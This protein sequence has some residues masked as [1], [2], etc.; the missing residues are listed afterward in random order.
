MI[1]IKIGRPSTCIDILYYN[2]LGIDVDIFI[3]L[4]EIII[5][6][7]YYYSMWGLVVWLTY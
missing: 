2:V 5:S 4:S 1:V 3:S 6:Q 7:L